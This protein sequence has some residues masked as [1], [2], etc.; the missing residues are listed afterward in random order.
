MS[1]VR[2]EVAIVGVGHTEQGE[3]PGVSPETLSVRAVRAALD[4]A[5][6]DRS[7]V[8][9]LIT[10]KSIQGLNADVTVGPLLGISPPY[11]Q[12]LDYGTCNFSLHLAVQ[13]ILSGLASTIVLC[14][15]ANARTVRFPFGAAPATLAGAAGLMHIAGPAAMALQRHKALYG[16]TDEQFGWIAVSEREWAARNPLA[17]FR[18]PMTMD[19]YLAMPYM[20]EPLRRPDVTMLADGGVALV[21]TT[22]ERAADFP[23]DPVYV[24]GIAEQS[25]IQ[26]EQ[27]PGYV[28]RPWLADVATRIWGTTGLKPSDIDALYIQNPTAVWVLQMLEAY[29]FCPEGEAGPWLAEGHTRPG[30]DLPLNTNGGQLSES[31]MW[32]WLHMVE[33]VRQLRG[34][35]GERQVSGAEVAMYCST[36]AWVKGGASILSTRT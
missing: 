30:G 35:A 26:G 21:V 27:R 19:D 10:C 16:T 11:S 23:H 17:I 36:Q 34:D 4:D 22:A 29:G 13:A 28:M 33:A 3:F 8:D 31:Y 1:E 2:G 24:L 7:A 15:G 14:Y 9:G 5:G 18:E 25:A 6:I 20:V 12:T 32:G